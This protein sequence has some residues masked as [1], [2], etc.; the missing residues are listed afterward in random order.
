MA[1]RE[2]TTLLIVAHRMS[3][4][5]CAIASSMLLDGRVNGYGPAGELLRDNPYYRAAV[6]LSVAGRTGA[7]SASGA[8]NSCCSA[9]RDMTRIRDVIFITGAGGF[10]GSNV[11]NV[12]SLDGHSVVLCDTSEHHESWEY[13]RATPAR[14]IVLA[15]EGM[16]WLADHAGDVSAIIHIG[17]HFGHHGN[18]STCLDQE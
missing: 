16:A 15:S 1:L 4:S 11:A 12:L 7:G 9:S 17:R 13:L 8:A 5:R 14:D 10:I 2:R 3:T 18:G 6:S